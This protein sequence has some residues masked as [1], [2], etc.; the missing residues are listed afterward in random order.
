M[1][2]IV[3]DFRGAGFSQDT[4]STLPHNLDALQKQL[5]IYSTLRPYYRGCLHI[6][7]VA[8]SSS[9]CTENAVQHWL[10]ILTG[11][12]KLNCFGE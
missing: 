5:H 2:L 4:G 11:I 9:F 10:I 12:I 8:Y 6:K 7:K 3:H 1:V